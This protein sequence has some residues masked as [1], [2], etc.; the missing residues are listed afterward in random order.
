M[1]R[2]DLIT[3]KTNTIAVTQKIPDTRPITRIYSLM[4]EPAKYEDE[5]LLSHSPGIGTGSE[6]S[7]LIAVPNNSGLGGGDFRGSNKSVE[8]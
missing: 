8:W 2:L 5:K 7:V 3:N 6:D 4:E 1:R